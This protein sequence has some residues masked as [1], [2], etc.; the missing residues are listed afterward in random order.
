M[1]NVL[2]HCLLIVQSLTLLMALYI[3]QRREAGGKDAKL[4]SLV[5]TTG[6]VGM[7]QSSFRKGS[8]WA[9]GSVSLPRGRSLC[10]AAFSSDLLHPPA[11]WI[12]AVFFTSCI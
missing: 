9:F 8:G 1:R 5:P 7:A 6:H 12:E 11:A 2:S 10:Q 3:F 4:F